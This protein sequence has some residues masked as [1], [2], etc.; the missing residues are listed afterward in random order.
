[1]DVL[2]T[3]LD[4]DPRDEHAVLTALGRERV[5]VH[6]VHAT[7]LTQPSP[8]PPALIVVVAGDR[9]GPAAEVCTRVREWSGAQLVMLSPSRQDADELLA[10]SA[11]CDDYIRTPCRT[12]SSPHGCEPICAGPTRAPV[13][14]GATAG[15]PWTR[16]SDA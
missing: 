12:P 5:D 8:H 6:R 4:C 15:W 16:T 9:P 3:V 7:E 2:L 1:M 14:G 11:G 10:F 13:C